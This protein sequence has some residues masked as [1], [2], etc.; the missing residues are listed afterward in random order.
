MGLLVESNWSFIVIRV[1]QVYIFKIF[2][3]LG[4]LCKMEC[5]S[6]DDMLYYSHQKLSSLIQK[7]GDRNA[8]I[9]DYLENLSYQ[10][11]KDFSEGSF[12]ITYHFILASLLVS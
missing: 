7:K 1:W 8:A 2:K 3:R 6:D 4:K 9:K 10:P 12:I 5:D 11:I